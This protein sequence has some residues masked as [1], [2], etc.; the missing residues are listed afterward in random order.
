LACIVITSG[1]DDRRYQGHPAG[2]A[3]PA[4]ESHQYASRSWKPSRECQCLVI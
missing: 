1:S 4:V 2:T 3:A